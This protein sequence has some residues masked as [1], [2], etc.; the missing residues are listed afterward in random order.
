[1][2]CGVMA[3]TTKEPL[4]LKAGP[5]RGRASEADRTHS[6]RRTIHNPPSR[7]DPST[8][9]AIECF[10]SCFSLPTPV[11]NGS[12]GTF[13]GYQCLNARQVTLVQGHRF[14]RRNSTRQRLR[15]A[16]SVAGERYLLLLLLLRARRIVGTRWLSSAYRSGP[17]V[18]YSSVPFPAAS[19]TR[20]LARAE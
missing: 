16:E 17:A 4:R 6:R 14:L 12:C 20:A 18:L 7:G 8:G 5:A 9:S 2:P 11:R 3:A 15:S 19:T 1:M 10:I 13:S